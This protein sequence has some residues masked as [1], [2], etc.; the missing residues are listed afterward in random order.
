M[1]IF[2]SNTD[3]IDSLPNNFVFKYINVE[4]E[5]DYINYKF[6]DNNNTLTF[7]Q[8]TEG[9][10]AI[11]K[12]TF[13][14][15]DIDREKANITYFL[16]VVYNKT[17]YYEESF[18]T[19]A[20]IESPYY[21]VYEINP[22]DINGKITLMAEGDLSNWAYLQVIAQIQQDNNLEYVSYK[23]VKNLKLIPDKKEEEK[24]KEENNSNQNFAKDNIYIIIII[25]M[26][27]IIVILLLLIIIHC[28]RS[29]SR[30]KI[31]LNNVGLLQPQ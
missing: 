12:C 17:H 29:P 2:K 3:T 4:K 26:G 31:E 11:I 27:V 8:I 1:N 15:V 5:D 28:I 24:E 14:K 9:N 6:V 30:N 25:I 10:N 13:N 19:I 18:D 21:T 20:I 23:A 22:S 7:D 16:K